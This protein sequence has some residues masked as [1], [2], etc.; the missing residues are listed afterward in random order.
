MMWRHTYA[1]WAK[2][3]G[4]EY[5][6]TAKHYS[7][8][9][10]EKIK[11]GEFEFTHPI[12]KKVTWHDS[13]HIGR[14]SGVYEEPRELIRAIPGVEFEEMAHN[15]EE[16]H[17]C[18]SVLTLIKEPPIA[19]DI[20]ESRLSEAVD[21]NAETVLGLCPC[22]EFQLRVT[23]D[24]KNVPV[25]IGD[26]AAFAC[27]GLGKEF[28]D[29]SPEVT[30]QWAV[31]EGM[32]DLM[33]PK[34]FAELMDTMWPEMLDAMPLGMGG[35][36][37]F[38]GKLG[39]VGDAMFALMKPVFPVLFPRLLPKMMPKVMPTMLDR[40]G[41]MIPMTDYMQEQMPEMMPKVMDNLMPHMLPDVVPHAVPKMID[42]L[43]SRKQ[44]KAA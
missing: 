44:Q 28:E 6:I 19:A 24:K 31:F 13:C 20:G 39:V 41:K 17:C 22:C 32:I 40:V 34:G 26:L 11:S 30:K 27:K 12:N 37:R 8:V 21:V 10:A 18:G 2:K 36:M 4:M 16:G 7:E 38:V 23:K 42:Y 9:V 1:D 29:P 43:R 33:T 5:N 14:V 35:M 15:R 3:L 25:E